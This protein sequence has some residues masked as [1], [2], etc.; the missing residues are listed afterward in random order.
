MEHLPIDNHND[1]NIVARMD[2]LNIEQ[3][4]EDE[5]VHKWH[6]TVILTERRIRQIERELNVAHEKLGRARVQRSI[7]KW[8]DTIAKKTEEREFVLLTNDMFKRRIRNY[9]RND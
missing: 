9:L 3:P 6:L 1:E 4:E 5:Q 2:G 8:R 7:D